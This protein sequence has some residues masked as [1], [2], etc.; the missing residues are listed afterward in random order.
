MGGIFC[1][2]TKEHDMHCMK[3][4]D[5]INPKWHTN[6]L[7]MSL[8]LSFVKEN[9]QF[10]R[11]N[12]NVVFVQKLNSLQVTYKDVISFDIVALFTNRCFPRKKPSVGPL[13]VSLLDPLH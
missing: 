1:L 12:M 7:L 8:D 4:S 9:K 2:L 11:I 3:S 5:Q 6:S 13:H 10:S